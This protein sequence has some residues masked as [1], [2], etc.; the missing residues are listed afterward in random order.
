M[1][2]NSF[3]RYVAQTVHDHET[4]RSSRDRRAITAAARARKA[5]VVR[6]IR[7][8]AAPSRS[9]AAP[10]T[11]AASSARPNWP[12]SRPWTTP[13]CSAARA[14]GAR[15]S[16]GLGVRARP[17]CRSGRS[18]RRRPPPPPRVGPGGGAGRRGSHGTG[19]SRPGRGRRPGP[20]L[21]PGR[22]PHLGHPPHATPVPCCEAGLLSP[23]RTGQGDIDA[24]P[25]ISR[26]AAATPGA[27]RPARGSSYRGT[28]GHAPGPFGALILSLIWS[29]PY[30]SAPP[31]GHPSAHRPIVSEPLAITG[32]DEEIVL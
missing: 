13:P 25:G 6:P 12:G 24:E 14:R 5:S 28:P 32:I 16:P 11:T 31:P 23:T 30:E 19:N 27:A 20:G 22:R 15:P 3:G 7:R 10:W 1:I 21:R 9:W 8:P 4:G 17:R 2:V 29:R 26:S 18:P